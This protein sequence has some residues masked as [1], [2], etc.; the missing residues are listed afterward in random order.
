M[1]KKHVHHGKSS[2]K[3]LNAEEVLSK[4]GL[5]EGDIF[6]DAGCGDGYF[7][8]AA[9]SIVGDSGKI[10]AIDIHQDSIYTLK[11]EIKSKSINNLVPIV[12]DITTK[13][14]LS[15]ESVDKCLIANVLHGFDKNQELDN[16]ISEISRIIKS[17]GNFYVVEFKKVK[18]TPGPPFE[19]RL[20]ESDIKDIIIDYGFILESSQDLGNY[21]ILLKFLKK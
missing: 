11:N 14:P 15:D 6:L 9:S 16:V 18:G 3:H 10:Y 5:S 12:A 4:I 19:V 7:S 13:I 21:H 1:V 8:I 17:S 2:R 20:S